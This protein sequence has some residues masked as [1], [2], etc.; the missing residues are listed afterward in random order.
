MD[1]SPQEAVTVAHR[2]PGFGD[3]VSPH[4]DYL[5]AGSYSLC[6]NCC[7]ADAQKFCHH[8]RRNLIGDQR[9]LGDAIWSGVREKLKDAATVV[10]ERDGA[11]LW[12]RA[13]GGQSCLDSIG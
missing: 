9:R 12:L 11:Q 6:R 1:G 13:R 4:I 10:V 2:S 8:L 7:P 3:A 5:A